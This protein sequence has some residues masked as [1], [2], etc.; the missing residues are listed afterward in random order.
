MAAHWEAQ[1]ASCLHVV[2]LNGA[3]EGHPKNLDHVL[4]IASA[5]SIPVQVGGGIR[6][7][8]T[9]RAYLSQGV[10]KVVLGT[11][12]LDNVMLLKQACEEFP[13]RIIVGVDVKHG[14]VAVR[15]WTNL[16]EVTQTQIFETLRPYPISA[17]VF[18]EIS[19]DGML[20]GPNL[21]ALAQAVDESPF[22]LIAS[23]GVTRLEDVQAVKQ[24]GEKVTGIIVGKA[25]YEGALELSAA[26]RVAGCHEPE[27]PTC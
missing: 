4:A 24:L 10:R 7:I 18:T 3:V 15:G 26:M 19:R 9:I 6:T 25:L 27:S 2:D 12:V 21:S 14:K 23:G 8:E 13:G 11:A 1:G 5:I 17:V 20:E 22:P 16:S